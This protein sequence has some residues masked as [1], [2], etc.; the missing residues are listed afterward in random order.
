[1]STITTLCSSKPPRKSHVS[2]LLLKLLCI[3]CT[4]S[5]RYLKYLGLE[6]DMY[7]LSHLLS[8]Q[9]SLLTTLATTSM[10]EDQERIP[11]NESKNKKED[12]EEM[13]LKRRQALSDIAEKIEGCIV[14]IG[15]ER[16]S[17]CVRCDTLEYYFC[18]CRILPRIRAVNIYTKET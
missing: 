5:N 11:L 3:R 18:F 1:M 15:R 14:S 16:M 12:D 13:D 9:R 2:I 4:Y 7:Q 8:E 17:V 10:F 6:G